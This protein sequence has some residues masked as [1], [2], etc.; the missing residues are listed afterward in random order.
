MMQQASIITIHAII[1]A[2]SISEYEL[3]SESS[4]THGSDTQ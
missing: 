1:A 3:E 4:I 2:I